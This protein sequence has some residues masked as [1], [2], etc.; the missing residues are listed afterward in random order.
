MT[1]LSRQFDRIAVLMSGVC[2][3]HCLLI[4]VVLML[5]PLLAISVGDDR[6]FHGLMLWLVLPVSVLG[7]VLGF[8]GHRDLRIVLAGAV[9]MLALTFASTWGHDNLRTTT[10]A[11]AMVLASLLLAVVHVWNFRAVRRCVGHDA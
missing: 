5:F 7:L 2:L 9:A 1:A 8:R 10:E 6:H 4:P 11:V 3:V